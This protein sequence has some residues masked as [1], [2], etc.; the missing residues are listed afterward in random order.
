MGGAEITTY[1]SLDAS[2]GQAR[3]NLYMAVKS[4]AAYIGLRSIFAQSGRTR[5]SQQAG[6][7]AMLCAR[8]I[9]GHMR[10][11]GF[12]PAIM[13][14]GND[15]RIIPAVEGLVFPL[16]WGETAAISPDG[17]FG[18]L[19]SAL[20]RH[21]KTILTPGVCKFEDGGWKLSS[22]NKNSWLSKI[23]LCQF[24]AHVV[25]GMPQDP[26]ADEAHQNWLLDPDNTYFAWSDQM[27]QGKAFGSKY[28]PRGVTSWLWLGIPKNVSRCVSRKKEKRSV[29]HT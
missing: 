12:I 15:S 23:Y 14:E 7:Q 1:D 13:E 6:K 19:I 16:I 4:W 17:E 27:V 25:F 26:E 11:D 3:N 21:L 10:G 28:Y 22:T 2:L 20:G 5:L 18:F 29:K 9:A 24:V 8:T